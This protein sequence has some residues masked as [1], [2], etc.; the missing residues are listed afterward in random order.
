[1]IP[2]AEGPIAPADRVLIPASSCQGILDAMDARSEPIDKSLA[3]VIQANGNLTV[4]EL[5]LH[6]Q[7]SLARRN[8]HSW[9]AIGYALGVTRQAAQQR[10][11][12]A[13]ESGT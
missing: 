8:G 12:G 1:M 7:V 2:V 9:A 13:A 10:F 11:G 5:T 3:L 6:R 4:A